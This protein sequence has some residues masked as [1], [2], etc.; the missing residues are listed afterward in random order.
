[1]NTAKA[2]DIDASEWPEARITWRYVEIKTYDTSSNYI[3]KEIEEEFLELS[4]T[5][6]QSYIDKLV[7]S[8]LGKPELLNP[9]QRFIGCA[10]KKETILCLLGTE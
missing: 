6:K 4:E 10:R 1:M 9:L 3:E 8:S 7:A 2:L 5:G